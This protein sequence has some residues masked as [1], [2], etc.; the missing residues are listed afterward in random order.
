MRLKLELFFGG[1][2][3][4]S[5]CIYFNTNINSILSAGEDGVYFFFLF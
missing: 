4:F 3:F 1:F 2:F 5:I